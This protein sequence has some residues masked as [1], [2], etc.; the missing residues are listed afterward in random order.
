MEM[1]FPIQ[2]SYKRLGVLMRFG[3]FQRADTTRQRNRDLMKVHPRIKNDVL[4][5]EEKEMEALDRE[6]RQ[7]HG[8]PMEKL[9]LQFA[10]WNPYKN[11]ARAMIRAGFEILRR[12]YPPSLSDELTYLEE[13]SIFELLRRCSYNFCSDHHLTSESVQK[14]RQ[15]RYALDTYSDTG[16][17]DKLGREIKMV[18]A[19][20]PI[21]TLTQ[22][23]GYSFSHKHFIVWSFAGLCCSE[24]FR[25]WA[26]TYANV[27]RCYRKVWKGFVLGMTALLCLCAFAYAFWPVVQAVQFSKGSPMDGNLPLVRDSYLRS[28]SFSF[29]RNARRQVLI[30]R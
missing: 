29:L 21:F 9:T 25:L 8:K 17:S 3:I 16:G 6:C 5:R 28:F 2:T 12:T 15:M 18:L 14:D 13:K 22:V 19:T 10:S 27:E 11:S 4:Y 26:G 20:L 7:L 24:M 23:V 30:H 1:P